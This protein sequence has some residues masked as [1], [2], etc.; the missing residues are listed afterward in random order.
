[1]HEYTALRYEVQGAQAVHKLTT[2]MLAAA[3]TGAVT[4]TPSTDNLIYR[5]ELNSLSEG[6]F[7]YTGH[8]GYFMEY[9]ADCLSDI[10][11]VCGKKC[12]T[13]SYIGIEPTEIADFFA[14][15]A[16]RGI[17]RVVPVGKTMD[18]S[19]TWD[20]YDLIRSLSRAVVIE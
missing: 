12:Q 2:A 18:F 6:V 7:D 11:P 10:L 9:R 8:S 15:Y 5:V 16:P 19:L 13:V 4:Y 1:L 3:K 14:Q 17:D 20:G